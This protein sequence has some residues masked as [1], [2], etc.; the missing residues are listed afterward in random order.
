[1]SALVSSLPSNCRLVRAIKLM[2]KPKPIPG[3]GLP[4]KKPYWQKYCW[5]YIG[6][7]PKRREEQ[8]LRNE[9]EVRAYLKE[10][11]VWKAKMKAW[12]QK[13]TQAKRG[14]AEQKK[15]EKRAAMKVKKEAARK[16]KLER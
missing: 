15:Q 11:A 3:V 13:R 10:L 7:D 9:K 14:K 12:K 5:Q 4:P 1:M 6:P 2:T 16:K 8:R